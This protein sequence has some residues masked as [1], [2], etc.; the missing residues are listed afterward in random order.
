MKLALNIDKYGG[1]KIVPVQCGGSRGTAFFINSTQLLTAWHV[2][3]D[4]FNPDCNDAVSIKI[5]G[6]D[7]PC[8]GVSF[9]SKY[10]ISL[11]E[12]KGDFDESNTGTDDDNYIPILSTDFIKDLELQ[13]IGYPQEI[14]NGVDY[15]G[16]SVR[17]YRKLDDVSKQFDTMVIRTDQIAF[18]T[19]VG[20][21]GSP[22]LNEF[23]SAIGVV[24]DQFHNSLGYTSIKVV[25]Q[26]LKDLGVEL[27]D[28]SEEQD[29]TR[30]GLGTCKKM[31]ADSLL[32]A[33]SRFNKEFHIPHKEFELCIKDF[34]DLDISNDITSNG[35]E[36]KNWIDQ[37]N[38]RRSPG[39]SFDQLFPGLMWYVKN[40]LKNKNIGWYVLDKELDL[41]SKHTEVQKEKLRKEVLERLKNPILKSKFIKLRA[42]LKRLIERKDIAD[43]KFLK[44]EANAGSGKTHLLCKFGQELCSQLPIYLFFG[45]Q[46]RA[47]EEPLTTISDILKWSDSDFDALNVQMEAKNKYAIFIIDALNEGVGTHFWKGHINYLEQQFSSFKRLKLIV[48]IRKT[49]SSDNLNFSMNWKNKTLSGFENNKAAIQGFF[50]FYKINKGVEDCLNIE[51]LSNPLCLKMYCATYYKMRIEERRK[52]NILK[53]YRKYIELRNEE[54]SRH[55]DEDPHLN[56]TGNFLYRL[57]S[58]SLF[59]YKCADLDRS[60]ARRIA[61]RLCHNRTWSNSLLYN[62]LSSN[63]ISEYRTTNDVDKITFEYDSMGDYLKVDSFISLKKSDREKL[64]LLKKTYAYHQQKYSI[65]NSFIKF[66]DFLERLFSLWNPEHVIWNESEC[67][68]GYFTRYILNSFKYRTTGIEEST[69]SKAALKIMFESDSSNLLPSVVLFDFNKYQNE[70]IELFHENLMRKSMLERDTSWTVNLNSIYDSY[71]EDIFTPIKTVLDTSISEQ[72]RLIVCGWLLTSSYPIVRNKVIRMIKTSLVEYPENSLFLIDKFHEVNDPYVLQGLY[73]AIYG[74]L[75]SSRNIEYAGF[76]ARK[77]D[78]IHYSN[79]VAPS[80]LIV[81]S[82][83]LKILEFAFYLDNYN[84]QWKNIKLPF[85]TKQDDPFSHTYSKSDFEKFFDSTEGG[86]ALYRSLFSWDFNRYII[87]TQYD[88][89]SESKIFY[90]DKKNAIL[91]NDIVLGIASI[92]KDDFGWN[93]ELG[94]LDANFISYNRMK[95]EKERIGKKY[96]WLGYYKV[97][98]YLCDTYDMKINRYTSHE[99]FADIPY[100]WYA[101]YRDSFDPSIGLDEKYS[102]EHIDSFQIGLKELSEAKSPINWLEDPSELPDLFFI[103]KDNTGKEWVNIISYDTV[104]DEISFGEG[105]DIRDQFIYYNSFFVEEDDAEAFE[106]WAKQQN[107]H[108]RWMPENNGYTDFLWNEYPW[109]DS[110][111]VEKIYKI[112]EPTNGCPCGVELSYCAQ[113]QEDFDGVKYPE[114]FASTV[115]IPMEDIMNKLD[116]Y[117][118]ERG[119]IRSS[120]SDEVVAFNHIST[121]SRLSGLFIARESLDEYLSKV[122]KRLYYCLLGEKQLRI[123]SSWTNV[124]FRDLT[125]CY[126]YQIGEAIKVVDSLRQIES[127]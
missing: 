42:E 69:L 90:K 126:Q 5:L 39:R 96:Q 10:D 1:S 59:D 27:L 32:R 62:A 21:S 117:T 30:F 120:K 8:I 65:D 100:P 113:L 71:E 22:V 7:I 114:V 84:T 29:T 88:P 55:V 124:Q 123:N 111:K 73:A 99:D 50:Q 87:G 40:G 105:I 79:N 16:V 2:V 38:S 66:V 26:E 31:M 56:V 44:I 35:E 86:R 75:L 95:N 46:F 49:V 103:E 37:L 47:D 107:F 116:L 93:N 77:I 115:Y 63:L 28:C 67:L 19:Y 11:L 89:D 20:F 104:V 24:T 6:K 109:S 60:E 82:R 23:G 83:T 110:Y 74:F 45:S 14:G 36:F 70:L 76:I 125:G 54:I 51:L 25:E 121:S 68:K 52:I 18:F 118:A 34:C 119:V 72:Q 102:E 98:A 17:N 41:E 97:L 43:A 127:E 4:H 101:G 122:N 85:V 9:Q 48:S 15:F 81:R 94:D 108:G 78:E 112:E 13:I 92:I 64:E 53:I 33:K 12:V 91:L 80:D 58:R 57:A 106:D 3:A 61:N